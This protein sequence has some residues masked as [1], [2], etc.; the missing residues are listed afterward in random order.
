[1]A[2]L[3]MLSKEH[4]LLLP[5]AV[6]ALTPLVRDWNRATLARAA[7]Y[8]ALSV[9]CSLWIALHRN[10]E[11]LVGTA[12]EIYAGQV[13]AQIGN[14]DFP[15][16]E[17]AMSIATQILLFW[18]YLFLWFIPNPQWMSVDLRIGFSGVVVWH[19]GLCGAGALRA[20]FAGGGNLL[21]AWVLRCKLP[22]H[23]A[24]LRFRPAVCGDSVCGGALGHPCSGA[25]RALPQLSWMPAYALLLTLLLLTLLRRLKDT[26]A[27]AAP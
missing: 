21:A 8:L 6:V 26:L 2:A 16:G 18:K 22:E 5:A 20:G 17:W 9:P 19:A 10:V 25:V 15:G 11:S 14:I 12:Y 3:S 27:L 23:P 13:S 1:M 4:A 24:G 7:G